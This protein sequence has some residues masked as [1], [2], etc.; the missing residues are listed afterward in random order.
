MLYAKDILPVY[1]EPADSDMV[2][3]GWKRGRKGITMYLTVYGIP[4]RIRVGLS[5]PPG[6]SIKLKTFEEAW[7]WFCHDDETLP[8]ET[9]TY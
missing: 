9:G 1:F 6:G 3:A 7:E 2:V 5:D 4:P 8:P